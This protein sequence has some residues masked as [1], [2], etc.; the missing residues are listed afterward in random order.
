[1]ARRHGGAMFADK[2]RTRDS[3]D[4]LKI[5]V[6]FLTDYKRPIAVVAG[7]ISIY[8]VL[9]TYQPII[10]QQALDTVLGSRDTAGL[11]LLVGLFVVVSILVWIFQ[12]L[13]TWL[14]ADISTGLVDKLRKSSFEK[15]VHADMAYHHKNQSGNVTSRVVNDTN[16]IATGLTVFTQ[17]STQ[18]LLIFA[19]FG[20]LI[21]IDW[22]IALISL[23]AIPVAFVISKVIGTIGRRRMLSSRQAYGKISGKLAENLAGVAIAK[24]FNQEERVSE[25]IRVLND[26]TYYYMKSLLSVFILVFP[27]ISMVSTLLVF[28]VLYTGGWLYAQDLI[29]IGNIF[30]A[31]IMVQR[32]LQP[33]INLSNNYT[34]LQASLAALDRITDIFEAY[35]AIQ[36]AENAQPLEIT[37]GRVDFDEIYF[38]YE[39]D[40]LVLNNINFTI[41]AGKKLALVGHTGAGKTTI[42]ALLL[43]FYDPLNGEIRIDG[44]NIKKVTLSS[45]RSS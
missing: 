20:I 28:G 5:L 44:Q 24:S 33:V 36:N 7:V 22:R 12:S 38:A 41:E 25:E 8:T 10:L 27:S 17:A 37:G 23:I 13:N 3:W 31:T 21:S 19:T 34:Q 35:P 42:T 1:M 9:A 15:L 40:N 18:L 43:R 4:L 2:S 14:M 39:E 26:Q 6:G 16:E 45:L 29:T 30:L 32:F 11:N